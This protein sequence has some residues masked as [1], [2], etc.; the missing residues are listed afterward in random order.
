[1]RAHLKNLFIPHK[2]NKYKPTI[3][4]RVSVGVMFVLVLLSFA[5][6]NIQAL[7]W[8]SSETLISAILPAVIV[9]LTNE[10]RSDE[11][12]GTLMRSPLL[13]QAAQ[14]KAFSGGDN[15]Q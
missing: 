13:D 9:D 10:E 2:G 11:A 15:C 14:L 12:L 3:L 5:I 7:L 4:E 6:A 8:I 1:M